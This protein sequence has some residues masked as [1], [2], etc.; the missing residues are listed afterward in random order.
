M[1]NLTVRYSL[2]QFTYWAASTGAVS[3]ATTY[4]LD[5]GLPSGIVGTLLALGGLLSCL[6]QPVLASMADKAKGFMLTKLCI[7]L[8]LLCMACFSLQMIS[9]LP[10]FAVGLLYMVG[11]WSAD[12]M[13]PFLNAIS[14]AYD[15]A[16]YPVNYCAARG[17]GGVASAAASL[18]LGIIIAKFGKVWMLLFL[19]VFRLIS[20]VILLG[21]PR[22]QKPVVREARTQSCTVLQFFSRYRWYCLSL[23]GILFLGMFHAMTE[24]FM[25]AIMERLGGD[26]SHVGTALFISS[27]CASPV[28]FF[29]ASVRK[30]IRDTN[31]L[32]IAAVSFLVKAVLFYFARSIT[33]I[34][35]LQ[36][37]QITSYAFLGPTQ[38][39]YAN[40]RVRESDMVKGQAFITAAYALGCAAGNF[41]GGQLL[42]LSV[43]AMLLAGIGM[44]L[45]GTVLLFLTVN[46]Q[47]A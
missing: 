33:A 35:L 16:G 43:D 22:I 5:K 31:L 32:K 40:A 20:I 47:D 7:I 2:S 27:M 3:F 13:V 39:F 44:A 41:A 25:I 30:R 21:Y 38:V 11:I 28:I 45:A 19:L 46:K 12:A 29:F 4:L 10:L 37:I 34:Y 26:S 24:N 17:I 9:G 23:L 6:T 1:K 42:T 14:V 36:F 15:G 8:S 18:V